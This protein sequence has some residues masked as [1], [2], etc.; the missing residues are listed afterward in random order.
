MAFMSLDSKPYNLTL[1]ISACEVWHN[2][3]SPE[4]PFGQMTSPWPSKAPASRNPL[5]STN[6]GFESGGDTK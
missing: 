4:D 2:K 3:L 5:A 6:L 1:P